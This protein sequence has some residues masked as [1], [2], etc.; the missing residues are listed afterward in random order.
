MTPKEKAEELFYKFMNPVDKLHKYPMCF[1]TAKQC[2]LIAVEEIQNVI[3][4]QKTTL[5]I[6]A[7]RTMDSFNHDI[8]YNE[9]LRREI[10]FYFDF[11]KQ[12]IEKL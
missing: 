1:D 2:A 7:Y 9:Y 10:I 4:L 6:T 11:V 12:E 5:T 3:S 8:E